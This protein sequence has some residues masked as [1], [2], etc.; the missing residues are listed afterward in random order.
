MLHVSLLGARTVVDDTTGEV[1]SRSS[2]TLALIALLASHAGTPQPRARIAGTFWPD[3]PEPQALTNLRRELHHLRALLRDDESVVVTPSDLTW[4]D[5][6]GCRVDLRIFD[7]ARQEVLAAA[8]DDDERVL[9]QGAA[10][11]AAYRGELLPG[12][13][14]DWTLARR[15]ELARG[16]VEICGLVTEAA[17]RTGQWDVALQVARRRVDLAPLDE[18]GHR[19]LI[20][21]QAARG[22]RAGAMRTYHHCASLLLDELGLEPDVATT[23]LVA[24]LVD[25]PRARRGAVRVPAPSA[26]P[27]AVAP[28]TPAAAAAGFVGRRAE[29][30]TLA[31]TMAGAFAGSVRAALVVGEAGV[32][33]SRL[34]AEAA[35]LARRHDATVAVA[36]C[37]GVPGRVALAPVADW[38]GHPALA[39]GLD[40]LPPLWRAEVARL[41]PAPEDDA[42]P[43]GSRGVVDAWQRHRFFQGLARALAATGRPVLLV[44]ENLQ[45]CDEVTLDFLSFLLAVESHEP[46]LIVLTGRSGDLRNAHDHAE[47]VRRTRATGQLTELELAPFDLAETGELVR[48]LTGQE[49]PADAVQVLGS[50]TGGFPLFVVE[51]ARHGARLPVEQGATDLDVVLRSRFEQLGPSARQVVGLAAAT[52]RDFDLDLLCEASDLEPHEVV[53]AVDELWRLRI[54]TERRTGYD[55]S[56]DLLRTTAYDLV[57]PAGRWLLHRRLAQ[58]LEILHAGRT[59]EV[60]AQLAE[61]Y[62]RARNP[63]RALE[64]YHRAAEVAARVFAHAEAIRLHRAALGQLAELPPGADRDLRE[65]RTLTA[66]AA[67]LN[68]HRGYSDPD[69]ADVLE[70]TIALAERLSERAVL[71]DAL[72]GLWTSRFVRGDIVRAHELATQA[73]ALASSRTDT[74]ALRGEA[75]FAFAGSAMTLGMPEVAAEH[76]EQACAL[77]SDEQS[78]SIGSHPA[79][80]AR[81]WAAHAHWLLGDPDRA[82]ASAAE[83]ID[84]ARASEHPYSLTIA[85]GYAALT[86][87]LLGEHERLGAATEELGALSDRHGFAYYAE[88]GLVLGGWARDDAAG[89]RQMERGIAHLRE[90]GAFARMPYWLTLLAAR[91]APDRAR[92]LLDSAL[93]SGRVRGDRWWLPEVARQRAGLLAPVEAAAELRSALAAAEEQGSRTLAERCRRDLAAVRTPGERRPS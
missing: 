74:G 48:V 71:M 56:H 77:S 70:R 3:S 81:A 34:V 87:Q 4:C 66:M 41:V 13:Y 27:S 73:L 36:H 63:A 33:T 76:F 93:V 16:C 92:A 18:E 75:H 9:A 88:W 79:I 44:L 6:A 90:A 52:G 7:R 35:R 68:A 86:W 50:A 24:E 82:A 60:A 49:L 57:S 21:L 10:A 8:P 64:Q 91:S 55:F 32:G 11:L 20:R 42:R 40:S 25:P 62:A 69:L 37:Y 17:R 65:I 14:D 31:A 5:G 72:V 26:A 30:R 78:L 58:G 59:D 12:L 28:A 19:E 29:L 84:R 39:A 15:E 46:L 51:A 2:R 85:L 38:L 47:W 23:R 61:Q 45:W 67:A 83:G 89:T 53:R 80:H 43:D 22:D 1:R 54:L